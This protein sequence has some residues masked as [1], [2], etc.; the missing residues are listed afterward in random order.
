MNELLLILLTEVCQSE[1]DSTKCL[2]TKKSTNEKNNEYIGDSEYKSL[3]STD[4]ILSRAYGLLKIHKQECPLRIIVSSVNHTF[5]KITF[6][7]SY[8]ATYNCLQ[9]IFKIAFNLLIN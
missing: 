8:I 2:T 5:Y 1:Q 9:V 3:L 7:L 4:D 6:F